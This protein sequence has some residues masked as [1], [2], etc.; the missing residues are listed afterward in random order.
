[1]SA[2]QTL[3]CP[4]AQPDMD[5]ALLIGVVGGTASEPHVS[6]LSEPQPI[7]DDLLALASP[8]EPTEVF[9][10]AAP[11]AEG[12]CQ[13]FDGAQCRLAA[14]VSRRLPPSITKLPPCRIRPNCRWW[15]EQG[16]A[17][18]MR[19]PFVVTTSYAPSAELRVAADPATPV[20][21]DAGS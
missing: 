4:S 11:C 20:A 7:S 5:R 10:V 2:E 14:K 13:H 3:F 21:I 19:C 8:V 16:R 12:G 1:V 9:R 15:R 18:C 17:A 6:Y